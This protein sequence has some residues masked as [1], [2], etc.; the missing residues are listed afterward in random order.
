MYVKLVYQ[1]A[2]DNKYA[3]PQPPATESEICDAEKKLSVIFPPELRALLSE[4]NGDRWLCWS[5][6]QIIEYNLQGREAFQEFMDLSQF[7]FFAG[8]G[9]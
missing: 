3:C 8:N 6:D 9:C 7:L 1:Y 4:M 5:I 2:M